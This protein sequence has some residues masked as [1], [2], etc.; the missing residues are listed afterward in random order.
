MESYAQL[1]ARY[2][3]HAKAEKQ[4][5]IATPVKVW[6]Q[7]QKRLAMAKMNELAD[8]IPIHVVLNHIN[9]A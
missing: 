9:Q 6:H 1:H 3:Y 2:C 8:L 7:I 5:H 4:V